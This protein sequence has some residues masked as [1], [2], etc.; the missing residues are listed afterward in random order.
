MDG[1]CSHDVPDEKSDE[2]GDAALFSEDDGDSLIVISSDD[3]ILGDDAFEVL[4]EFPAGTCSTATNPYA[5]YQNNH[6]KAPCMCEV[7]NNDLL[8]IIFNQLERIPNKQWSQDTRKYI[9]LDEAKPRANVLNFGLTSSKVSPGLFIAS[10]TK[11]HGALL[12]NL[13]GLRDCWPDPDFKYTSI[14]VVK[15]LTMYI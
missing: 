12:E 10:A 1:E 2:D 4:N 15:D 11:K 8:T 14:T 3:S 5:S 6:P 13:I 9:V 7:G